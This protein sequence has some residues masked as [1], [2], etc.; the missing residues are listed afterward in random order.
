MHGELWKRTM[1]P[2]TIS[3]KGIL[4]EIKNQKFRILKIETPEV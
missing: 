2:L 1:L 4:I 3:K